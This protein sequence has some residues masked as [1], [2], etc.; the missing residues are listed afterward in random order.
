MYVGRT[1]LKIQPV[2]RGFSFVRGSR[3]GLMT[4]SIVATSSSADAVFDTKA[5]APTSR[6]VAG[7]SWTLRSTILIEG[8]IRR[9]SAA[10]S[11]PFMSG[12]ERSRMTTSGES[13]HTLEMASRP[14][15]ASPQASQ[16]CFERSKVRTPNRTTSLSS[17]IRMRSS[18]IGV[19]AKL[20][21][22]SAPPAAGI[23]LT[24]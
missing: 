15:A 11:N 5:S 3:H 18:T 21:V 20:R 24:L 16:S 19:S 6:A 23:L 9:I 14:F 1:C 7:T 8:A 13:S 4:R 2:L 10:A 17:A 22:Y 12:I